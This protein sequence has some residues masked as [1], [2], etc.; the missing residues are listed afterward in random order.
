MDTLMSKFL[1]VG[2]L[3]IWVLCWVNPNMTAFG[4]VVQEGE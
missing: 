1:L 3:P 4:R 2:K